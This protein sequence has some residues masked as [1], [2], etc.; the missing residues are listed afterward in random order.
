MSAVANISPAID[1]SGKC[2]SVDKE[3]FNSITLGDLLDDNDELRAGDTVYVGDATIPKTSHL[4]DAG[5]V[6]DTMR[7]RASDIGGEYA[8]DYPNVSNEAE[9]ELNKFLS[10][11]IGKHAH[12]TFYTVSNVRPYILG[13]GDF[14]TVHAKDRAA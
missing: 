4:C 10:E 11:W 3:D 5:D 8:E 1:E 7:D 6:I 2:W 13:A 12:P 14:E 9:A